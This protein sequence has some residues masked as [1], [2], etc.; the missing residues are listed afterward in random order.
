MYTLRTEHTC[1]HEKASTGNVDFRAENTG[2][3]CAVQEGR[4]GS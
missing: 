4:D 2:P 1:V 3:F